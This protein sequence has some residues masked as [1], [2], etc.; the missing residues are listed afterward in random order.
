MDSPSLIRLLDL[1]HAQLLGEFPDIALLKEYAV[2]IRDY[3]VGKLSPA[4]FRIILRQ[5]NVTEGRIS[6]VL[7]FINEQKADRQRSE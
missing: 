2:H 7:K 1:T 3:Y 5:Y 6:E 4:E